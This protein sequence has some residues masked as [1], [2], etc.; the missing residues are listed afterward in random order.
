MRFHPRF[1]P[2]SDCPSRSSDHH[3]WCLKGR[4]HR[5][6]DGR[7]VQRFLC[8]ECRRTFSTQTFRVDYRLKKPKLNSSLFGPFISK[9][10]HRQAARVL[11]CTRS[12]VAH[13]LRLLGDH[14][15]S[16]HR[17]RL[18]QAAGKLGFSRVFQLDEL[19]TFEHSRRLAPVTMPVLI[20]RHSYFILDLKTAPL[21]CRGGLSESDRLRKEERER[22]LGRRRSGSRG[23]VEHCADTLASVM[24]A[25]AP[26]RMQ[27]DRKVTCADI[28]ETIRGQ[29][30]TSALLLEGEARLQE[31]TLP[32]Q[33]HLGDDARRDLE[34]RAQKLGGVEAARA[35]R[36]PRMDLG[37]LAQLRAGD[38]QQGAT[39]HAGDGAGR[40]AGKVERGGALCVEG[41]S[42]HV[43]PAQ[44][45]GP[46]S[47]PVRSRR[48][49]GLRSFAIRI[50]DVVVGMG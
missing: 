48:F 18:S 42:G 25:S 37:H 38:H 23:A 35:T 20:E 11:G 5:A 15:R 47:L 16:F 2:R 32:D 12:T 34:A 7:T 30:H 21:P 14:C 43:I 4:F 22:G 10:T 46:D 13:R 27:T 50:R 28:R 1:C 41:L 33:P 8:L 39:S 9:V 6:C 24:A 40:R 26:V 19:E 49:P 44:W 36:E 45:C 29:S 17:W 31:P 3:R